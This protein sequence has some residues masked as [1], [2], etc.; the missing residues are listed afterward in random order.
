MRIL[1][2]PF[3]HQNTIFQIHKRCYILYLQIL[4]DTPMSPWYDTKYLCQLF[5]ICNWNKNIRDLFIDIN[6][7]DR[8]SYKHT[9][10]QL[11]QHTN[12]NVIHQTCNLTLME[13][14]SRS[15]W[16]W[17]AGLTS[18]WKLCQKY[19]R[20]QSSYTDYLQS[21]PMYTYTCGEV[22]SGRVLA[23]HSKASIIWYDVYILHRSIFIAGEVLRVYWQVADWGIGRD[24]TF[25]DPI[26]FI[27]RSAHGRL[28]LSHHLGAR[29]KRCCRPGLHGDL[30]WADWA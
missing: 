22:T 1:N 20:H 3:F 29:A 18:A 5:D 9:S 2:N 6:F 17:L 30:Q 4:T 13:W 14:N 11:L 12:N 23:W 10:L 16:V 24:S 7:I 19:D 25:R 26:D 27:T 21:F 28:S 15:G 8:H